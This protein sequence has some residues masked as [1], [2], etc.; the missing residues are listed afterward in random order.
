MNQEFYINLNTKNKYFAQ[1]KELLKASLKE[2]QEIKEYKARTNYLKNGNS[3]L[4]KGIYSFDLPSVTSCPN[5]SQCQNTC[6]AQKGRF[7]FGTT[8]QSNTK[9]FIIALNDISHLQKSIIKEIKKNDIRTIRIHSSG[10]FFS[11]EYFLMWVAIANKFHDTLKI[12]TYSKAP[13]IG[14]FNLPD[15]FNII[16]SFI[17]LDNNTKILNYGS[18]NALKPIAKKIKGLICPITKGQHLDKPKLKELTCTE[19][20]Y[21]I[22]KKLPLFVQH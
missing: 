16:D 21:C 22:T 15:N 6:Y 7:I 13:Q 4:G 8:K 14:N 2:I 3:K 17:H 11:K 18:Y 5:Y 9:N 12:F 10:D 1:P 20:K 19:C